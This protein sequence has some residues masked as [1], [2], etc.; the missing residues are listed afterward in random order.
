[1]AAPT[2][3]LDLQTIQDSVFSWFVSNFPHQNV[4]QDA[5]VDDQ[6]LNYD[7]KPAIIL[8]F[9]DMRRSPR[10]RSFGG[11]RMDSYRS[12]FD[13]VVV[14]KT[15]KQ[16]R[17]V[18]NYVNN[19][20]VGKKFTN[21]GET[22]KTQSIWETSRAVLDSANKPSRFAATSRFEYGVFAKRVA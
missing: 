12:G 1:M 3:D 2:Y 20:V 16:A 8:W 15:G 9:R 11:T 5:L 13:V 22:V 7:P 10:G 14:A 19:Q 4:Y 6:T 17:Q 18:L 21:T